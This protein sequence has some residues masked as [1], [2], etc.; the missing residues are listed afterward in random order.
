[1]EV[2]FIIAYLVASV[3]DENYKCFYDVL[4]LWM[5][6]KDEESLVWNFVIN[7]E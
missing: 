3:M 4:Q 2:P 7:I 6:I 5:K 1:M